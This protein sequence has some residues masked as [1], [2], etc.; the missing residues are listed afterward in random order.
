MP[1]ARV[2]VTSH[3]YCS[4]VG[5][6]STV[7]VLSYIG[8]TWTSHNTEST[9]PPNM[10]TSLSCDCLSWQY[11]SVL[12]VI[13]KLL[14][15]LRPNRNSNTNSN[16]QPSGK[17]DLAAI[18]LLSVPMSWQNQ[19]NLNHSMIPKSTHTLLPDLEAIE[20]VMVVKKG[21]NLK[22]KGKGG[23]APS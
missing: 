19:Y 6:T 23:T 16:V 10:V 2:T 3:H 17:A 14:H 22:A 15:N 21:A 20:Q 12:R 9:G 5:T 11:Y 13:L 8:T 18:V 1:A 7:V 4:T